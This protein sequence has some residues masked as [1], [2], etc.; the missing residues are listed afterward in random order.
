MN[1][2]G[3][4]TFYHVMNYGAVLQCYALQNVINEYTGKCTVIPYV[5][6]KLKENEKLLKFNNFSPI[7]I[8]KLMSQGWGN[9]KKRYAFNR[10]ISQYM[11]V[12]KVINWQAYDTIV[13]GSDQVWNISLTDKDYKY[14]LED[15]SCKKI[16]YAASLG[17]SYIPE[18]EKERVLSA[19]QGF[20]A[21]SFRERDTVNLMNANG[22]EAIEVVDP[23]LLLE[24]TKW[25]DLSECCEEKLPDKYI[26]IYCVE[27]STT[28]FKYARKIAEQ[29]GLPI[30]YLNQNLFFKEKG[31]IYKR[32]IS[33]IGFLSYIRN[34]EFVITNSFHGTAFS[35]I[36]EKQFAS[37]IVWHGIPNKRI[38]NLLKTVKLE[39][40]AIEYLELENENISTKINYK[41]VKDRLNISRMKSKEYLEKQLEC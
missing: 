19:I 24:E 34:A 36:F 26:L 5:C 29:Y 8:A 27:K 38:R 15:I 11:K 25:I 10:F 6:K 31:F 16:A 3:I 13:V 21:V 33:P 28:V 39:N 4:L 32:G 12:D 20:D 2:V 40:R 14:F 22:I 7:N 17:E 35:I 41:D 9:K 18:E 30:I 1:K 23:V 37:D